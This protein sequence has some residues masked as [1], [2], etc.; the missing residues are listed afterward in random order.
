[1]RGTSILGKELPLFGAM[2]RHRIVE[3]DLTSCHQLR[4][5]PI[6]DILRISTLKALHCSD[7]PKLKWP[8]QVCCVYSPN[9]HS[10]ELSTVPREHHLY[11][12]LFMLL[13]CILVQETGSGFN[14]SLLQP[15][16]SS[17]F[18][19]STILFFSILFFN[20]SLLQHSLLHAPQ[21]FLCAARKM[22]KLSSL[23]LRK[24]E[25]AGT[26][27]HHVIRARM[28]SCWHAGGCK[29]WRRSGPRMLANWH[30]RPSF[31]SLG[32]LQLS[33]CSQTQQP[34]VHCY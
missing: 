27:L 20:H 8:P 6:D 24:Y 9:T 32:A 4:E 13:P 30:C 28:I 1:M 25:S 31:H 18:S 15:F 11:R 22:H 5:L 19:S 29:F 14:H 3:I 17:A 34:S 10:K 2:A 16:S 23:W 12:K 33:R 7:C 26:C 21:S